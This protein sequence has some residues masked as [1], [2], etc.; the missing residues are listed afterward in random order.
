MVK[1]KNPLFSPLKIGTK[2]CA[3]LNANNYRGIKAGAIL[4]EK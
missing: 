1:S 4:S 3:V 2:Q